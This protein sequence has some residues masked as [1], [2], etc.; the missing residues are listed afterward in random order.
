MNKESVMVLLA[1]I[2]DE[3]SGRDLVSA[4]AVREVGIHEDSVSVDIRLGYPVADQGADL[5]ARI[6]SRLEGDAGISSASVNVS[7]K[8]VP[9]KVQNDLKPLKSIANVLAVG[10]GKGGVG[11]STTAVNLAL[12]LQREGARVGLLDADIYG[13]SIPRMLGVTGQPSIEGEKIVPKQAYGLKVMSIGFLVEEESAMIWR[14]PMVTSALQQLLNDTLWGTLDYLIIDLPPGTGDIQLTLA[15]KI[16]TAG[17]VI[18]TTPQDIALLD[19]RRAL[20]MFRKVGVPVLGVVENMSTHIC[21]ACGHEEAIFGQGGGEQMAIDFE[22]P[23]LGRLPLAMEIRASL[24]EGNP[25]VVKDPDSSVANSYRSLALRTAGELSV[26]PRSMV[27]QM[28][29]IVIQN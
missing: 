10:S 13:P 28:P 4:G 17:A 25:T 9:H 29:E 20:H 2:N 26:L 24:D 15:Q 16:P 5:A 11:K 6:K 14:G 22:I 18:V 21:T 7:F 3:N 19:A 1:E 27:M 12:A 8:V 23:L